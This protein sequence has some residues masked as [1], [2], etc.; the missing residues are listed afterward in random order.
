MPNMIA[1]SPM[2]KYLLPILNFLTDDRLQ[3]YETKDA[4]L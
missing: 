2:L 1:I 4:P 3:I